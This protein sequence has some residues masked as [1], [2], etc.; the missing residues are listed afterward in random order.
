MQRTTQKILIFNHYL[1]RSTC[2]ID[3]VDVMTLTIEPTTSYHGY[4]SSGHFGFRWRPC[5]NTDRALVT[6]PVPKMNNNLS[7]TLTVLEK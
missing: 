4:H 1:D 6:S 2:L 5:S 3:S 7:L